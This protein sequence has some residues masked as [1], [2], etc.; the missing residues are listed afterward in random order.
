MP[1][2]TADV[3]AGAALPSNRSFGLVFTVVFGVMALLPLRH[4]NGPRW[5]AIGVSAA[6]LA[7]AIAWPRAL[8]PANYLWF[9]FGRLLHRL[10]SPVVMAILF[11]GV[12]TPAGRVRQLM[13]RG[14]ARSLRPDVGATTYWTRRSDEFSPM[15]RQ[16]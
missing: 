3:R 15:N 8:T 12:I 6:I 10:V 7:V 1:V 5:W 9:R 13:R 4:G 14:V 2:S 11:Y 16:F